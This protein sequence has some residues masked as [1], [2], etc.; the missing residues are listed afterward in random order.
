MDFNLQPDTP[1]ISAFRKEVREWL[2]E[3][4]RGSEH[5]RWSARWSTRENDDE[6]QFRRQLANKLGQ[7]RWLFPTY[8]V[9]YGGAGLTLDHQFVLETEIDRYGLPLGSIFYTL[10][11]LVAPAVLKFGTEEQKM[12]FLPPMLRGELA[13]WQVL[14]EPQGGSDVAHC[15]TKAIRDGDDYIV[16]GQKIM[17][18]HHLPLIV[19][20][21]WSAPI[22]EGN[23]TRTWAGSISP[24]IFPASPFSTCI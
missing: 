18:G 23:G 1:E 17:V 24:P 7:K 13:V 4:M 8:P 15:L 19:S 10:A 16:N 6:Y 3:N 20:G 9:Q 2:A 5:L 14:T 21:L 11:R 12:E 22:R